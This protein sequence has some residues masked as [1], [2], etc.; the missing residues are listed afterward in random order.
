MNFQT[1]TNVID[2]IRIG[3]QA[4]RVRSDNRRKINDAAN[5]M[6]PLTTE[7]AR[8]QG[9]RVNVNWMEMPILFAN[10]GRQYTRAFNGSDQFFRIDIPS[11]PE[12]NRVDWSLFMGQFINAKMKESRE[13]FFLGQNEIKALVGHGLAPGIWWDEESWLRKFVALDDFRVPTDTELSFRNLEW[14]AIRVPYTEGE[15]TEKVFGEFADENWKKKPI[16]NILHHYSDKNYAGAGLNYSWATSPE[17]VAELV[18]QNLGYFC[19]DAVP[20]IP[21]WHFYFKG[22]EDK[23]RRRPWY[24]RVVPDWNVAGD[25]SEITDE[26]LYESDEPAFEKLEHFLHVQFGDLSNTT[27]QMVYSIRSLGYE[28]LEPCFFSNLTIC[29]T[30]QHLFDMM[31]PWFSV[32]DP[33]GKARAQSVE[34]G[35]RKILPEGVRVVPNTERHQID[36]G[37]LELVLSQLKQ[38]MSEASATYTQQ[39]DTGTQKEQTAY[40]TS[41]K[42]SMVNAMMEGLLIMAFFQKTFEYR[43]ICRRFCLRRTHDED[44]RAFQKACREYGIPPQYVNVELWKVTPEQP[45]GSGNPAMAISQAQQLLQMRPMFGPAAQQ[46]ILHEV[47]AILLN[48]PRKA[49][50][51]APLNERMYTSDTHKQAEGDFNTCMNG[52]QPQFKEGLSLIEEIEVLLVL[53]HGKAGQMEQSGNTG[54]AAEVMGLQTLVQFVGGL[55][56]QLAQDESQQ[57]KVKQFSD[58]LGQLD[59]LVKG[60]AQRLQEQQQQGQPDPEAMAKVQA[61]AMQTQAKI[62]ADQAKT[63]QKLQH[64]EQAFRQK[65]QHQDRSMVADEQRESVRAGAEIARENILAEAEAKRVEEKPQPA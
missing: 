53:G 32:T 26:F 58:I 60:F 44:A 42:V 59:N 62:G 47:T 63:Q 15:L 22:K 6:P 25:W 54:T 61:I 20:T 45:M 11:A 2:T 65:E 41:V 40:E 5:A 16:S 23:T 30:I 19:S 13:Y 9:V 50:R 55:I 18:K 34:M 39:A 3:D 36:N 17:K 56:Q 10:A 1:A 33:A 14:V 31:N 49:A 37:L 8:K 35:D 38:R 7:E 27:P 52:V 12:E 21:L 46:E 29:K 28:L 4:A 24:L 43:E 57:E 64:K 48:D 51:W